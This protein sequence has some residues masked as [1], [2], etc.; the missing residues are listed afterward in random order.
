[1]AANVLRF[2]YLNGQGSKL[3]TTLQQLFRILQTRAYEIPSRYYC[4]PEWLFYALAKLCAE[5]SSPDLDELRTVITARLQERMGCDEDPL[6]AAMRVIAAQ[7]LN[8][9][10]P[11][12]LKTLLDSQQL[13]GGWELVWMWR[14]GNVDV[15]M[16][17]RFIPTALAIK[18]IRTAFEIESSNG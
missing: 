14:Y 4:Q 13:D 12:D 16:G 6:A 18:A 17:S 8:L 2:F 15:K 11:R 5:C 7:A 3:Q 10:N 1:M 9:A